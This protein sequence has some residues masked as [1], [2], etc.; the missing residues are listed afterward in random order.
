MLTWRSALPPRHP[1]AGPSR[2]PCLCCEGKNR[3]NEAGALHTPR[4]P[5]ETGLTRSGRR[6]RGAVPAPL[7]AVGLSRSIM[8]VVVLTMSGRVGALAAAWLEEHLGR[9]SR[10]KR[11]G[12]LG[13]IVG[14]VVSKVGRARSEK[15]SCQESGC[16]GSVKAEDVVYYPEQSLYSG[17]CVGL[18]F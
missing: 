5:P 12:C 18:S 4:A 3:C 9:C 10:V 8:G 11:R 16:R 6:G 17:D 7:G 1:S 13:G 2:P 14:V 15:V